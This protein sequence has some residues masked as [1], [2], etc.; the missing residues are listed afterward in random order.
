MSEHHWSG[1]I[2]GL[3]TVAIVIA[4]RW[5]GHKDDDTPSVVAIIGTIGICVVLKG[6]V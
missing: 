3:C 6:C 1:V 2:I 4:L 5:T